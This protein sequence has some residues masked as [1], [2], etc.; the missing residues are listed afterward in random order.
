M[1]IGFDNWP[2][3]AGADCP[4]GNLAKG[5]KAWVFP[6]EYG[7]SCLNENKN[8]VNV[9]AGQRSQEITFD[10]IDG[11]GGIFRRLET[12]PRWQY[13]VE[14]WGIHSPSGT[15][16]ELFL[17]LDPSGGENPS[18][19]SVRWF[20]WREKGEAAWV[21]TTETLTATGPFLTIFLKG[22]HGVA[23]Q[24]GATLFDDVRI[25]VLTQD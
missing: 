23:V 10:F 1:E 8:P 9:H 14:A 13:T 21:R 20:P 2:A 15:P 3:P 12:T 5:W 11:E 6:G 7:Y 22:K 17:G 24:G 4:A 25:S 19:A 18:A 16:V